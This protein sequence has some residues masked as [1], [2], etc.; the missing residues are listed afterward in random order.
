MILASIASAGI[1]RA[2][3]VEEQ[4]STLPWEGQMISPCIAGQV[5]GGTAGPTRG[6]RRAACCSS[7]RR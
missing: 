7:G 6:G 5:D 2:T 4:L 1:V 3:A